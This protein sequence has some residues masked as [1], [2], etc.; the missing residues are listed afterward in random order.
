MSDRILKALMQLFAIMATI[1]RK[2]L[3]GR[4]VVESFL[5]SQLSSAD[6][7]HYLSVFD[8]NVETLIGKAE[9]GKMQKRLSASSVK[10]L[11]ICTDINSEL[12][13]H[14][15]YIVLIRL[16][17]FVHAA[18]GQATETESELLNTVASVFNFDPAET[19]ACLLFASVSRAEELPSLPYYYFINSDVHF[20]KEPSGHLYNESIDGHFVILHIRSQGIFFSRYFGTGQLTLNGQPVVAGMVSVFS[21]GS[22]VRGR[23]LRP[24]YYSDIQQSLLNCQPGRTITFHVNSIEYVFPNGNKGLHTLSFKVHSGNLVGIMG[25]SGA[26]KSTLLNVLNG[27]NKPSSGKVLINNI[28]IHDEREKTEG[29]IGYVPQDDLLMEELTVF[30]NLY[31]NT[32]LCFSK[33]GHDEIHEKVTMLLRQMGLEAISGLKVGDALNNLISG[34]QRKRLNIALE[35]IRKPPVLFVDEPTSGLSSLDSEHVMD[36][37]KQLSLSGNLVFV[38][39]HQPSSD[40]FKMFDKLLILDTGGYPVYFGN[41]SDALIYFNRQAN[42][43]G[44]ADEGCE[45]CGNIN[46]EQIFSILES[47]IIDEF[48][49]QTTQRKITPQEWNK[50]YHQNL[51]APVAYVT[52]GEE[53]TWKSDYSRPSWLRQIT[54]F[55]QRDVLSKLQNLQY[56]LINFL[57]APLLACILAFFLRYAPSGS[58]YVFRENLNLPAFI[59]IS[60][61][62]ALFMGLTVSAEE[63][64]RDRKILKRESFLN[65][66]R[67]SYLLSK[68][69]VLFFISAVQTLS[70]VIIGNLLFGIKGM[71][72]P[73]WI[74]L[75]SV[76]CFS[77]LMGLNISSAFNSAVTIYILIPF[78]IIPQIILSGVLVR[79]ENLN[80]AVTSQSK[81]PVIGE[82]MAS[83]WAFEALAVKQFSSNRYEKMFF[84]QDKIMSRAT[85][86][87]DF[88]LQRMSDI[89]DSVCSSKKIHPATEKIFNS[90]LRAEWN[91][92]QKHSAI[93][94]RDFTFPKLSDSSCPEYNN[95]LHLLRKQY[96]M[97]YNDAARLKDETMKKLVLAAGED[98]V[99][100]LKDDY[101]NESLDDLVLNAHDFNILVTA[102]SKLIQRYRPVFMEGEAGSLIRAPFYVSKKN[103]F[104][105]MTDTWTVNLLMIWFM[106]IMLAVAL[107]FDLL[108]KL[109]SRFG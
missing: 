82:L 96:I 25:G 37:L 97:E 71:F 100:R 29:L 69:T 65:L 91:F 55:I 34:G 26:G 43:A 77:N 104:G 74:M 18:G 32:K 17:E 11:K 51:A 52:T 47:K 107:Y 44:T 109:I 102:E 39:I 42:R 68:T 62:V 106:S 98:G 3:D 31:Y 83:R 103:F 80:P 20:S 59:F 75:F 7:A 9:A 54:V 35:L 4:S 89:L 50:L 72:I 57:E 73:Y 2:A 101:T 15:K 23:N 99:S 49:N 78:L 40:I 28:S 21:T 70:F 76:S 60:V 16:V 38:V 46:P 93:S 27:N 41:P 81:V 94:P 92:Q 84:E 108:K 19:E 8:Q 1:E 45:T 105:R 85:F 64:I 56:L 33:A 12:D 95:V 24:I 53:S 13:Q 66:S 90:E 88:W 6:V 63:I 87:K 14:Q 61:I 86:R 10:I 79:F 22:V 58:G 36:M 5:K 67:G 30:Q 48:G